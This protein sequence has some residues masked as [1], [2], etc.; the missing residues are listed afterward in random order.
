M[1]LTASDISSAAA[2]VSRSGSLDSSVASNA[3]LIIIP[4]KALIAPITAAIG[5]GIQLRLN[6]KFTSKPI[7]APN[8]ARISGAKI[9]MLTTLVVMTTRDE[10]RG[11]CPHYITKYPLT[12]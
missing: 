8:S 6:R 5:K 1:M 4:A 7:A 11:I 3:S 2:S 10:S 12:K 9:R